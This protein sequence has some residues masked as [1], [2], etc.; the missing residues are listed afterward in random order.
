MKIKILGKKGDKLEFLLEGSSPA[1]ANELRRI[2]VTEVPVLAV[3]FVN[4]V[5]NTSALYDEMIAH[6]LGLIPLVFDPKKFNFVEDCKCGGKG[7]PLCQAVFALEKSGPA[8]VYSGDMRSSNKDVKPKDNGFPVT[9]LLDG[10]NIKL[11]A[12]AQL[13]TGKTHS[14][15]QAANASY[16]YFPEIRKAKKG[17]AEKLEECPKQFF[18]LKDGKPV[19]KDFTKL[20]INGS[21]RIG[22]YI[23]EL[24]P[25]KFI[26]RVESVSGLKPEDIAIKAAEIL[27]G[28]GEEFGKLV[29][30]LK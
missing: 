21:C 8:T 23:L 10:Q 1:F 24:N 25:T 20:D 6:R 13:G 2:M 7:C 26:F 19:I 16:Q 30:K 9:E 28:K 18:T 27:A 11:E 22:D 3:E 29:G 12:V 15:F 5:E 14:K 17:E 4:I